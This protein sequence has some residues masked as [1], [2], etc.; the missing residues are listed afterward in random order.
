MEFPFGWIEG[1][2]AR[3]P[4]NSRPLRGIQVSPIFDA[5]KFAMKKER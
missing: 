1:E 3:G 2:L 5:V 4:G